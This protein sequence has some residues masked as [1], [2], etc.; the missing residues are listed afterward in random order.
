MMH[1]GRVTGGGALTEDT[2]DKNSHKNNDC[3]NTCRK[4]TTNIYFKDEGK[5]PTQLK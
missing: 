1:Q 3:G 4:D 5:L 2:I